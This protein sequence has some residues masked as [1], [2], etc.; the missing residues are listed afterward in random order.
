[1]RAPV[2]YSRRAADV[3][4]DVTIPEP[5]APSRAWQ[6]AAEVSGVVC[7]LTLILAVVLS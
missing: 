7:V 2:F 5:T 3:T 6:T 1:M 4:V